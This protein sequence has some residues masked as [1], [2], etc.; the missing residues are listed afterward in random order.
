MA[1]EILG[2]CPCPECGGAAEVKKQKNGMAYRWCM[3]CHAQYFPRCERTSLRLLEK[4]GIKSEP[5]REREPAPPPVAV[6]VPEPHPEAKAA[7][8]P[9]PQPA[10]ARPGPFDFLLK[11]ATP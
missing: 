2:T 4:C 8:V 10:P 7:P 11:G 1:R 3:D 9:K 6:L 5:V